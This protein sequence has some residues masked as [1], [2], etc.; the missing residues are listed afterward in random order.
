MN[1][2]DIEKYRAQ[3]QKALSDTYDQRTSANECERFLVSPAAQWEGFARGEA[4][5]RPRYQMDIISQA[6]GRFY[7]EW[8]A[9]RPAVKYRSEGATA[10]KDAELLTGL[11]RKD[12]SRAGGNFA[13]NNAVKSALYGGYG[14]MKLVA[15]YLDNENDE[16]DEQSI[17]F[18]PVYSAYSTVV[19]VGG[20][21]QDKADSRICYE[22]TE[23]SEEDWDD[24]YP[25]FDPSS[26]MDIED[27]RENGTTTYVVAKR[28]EV[29]SEKTEVIYFENLETRDK[30]KVYADEVEAAMDEL[31]ALGYVETA[32]RKMNRQYVECC[33]LADEVLEKPRRIAGKYIPIV[34]FYGRWVF[35]DGQEQY[36]G[37]VRRLMDAQRLTNMAVSNVAEVSAFSPLRVPYFTTD[38]VKGHENRLAQRHIGMTTFQ[39]VNPQKN[40]DGSIAAMGPVGYDEPPPVP[41]ATAS[42]IDICTNYAQQQ[43]G[44]NPADAA[45]S[46]ASFKT[47]L[48][49]QTRI[50]MNT[51]DIVE[52]IELSMLRVGEVYRAMAAEVHS[53][54]K[55]ASTMGA[56]GIES[57]VTM[58]EIIWDEDSGQFI[59]ISDVSN[60]TFNV[61]V[62]VG[63]SYR[64]MRQQSAEEMRNLAG[65]LDPADPMRK[66]IIGTM[67]ENLDVTN[68]DDLSKYNRRQ[69]LTGGFVDPRNEEEEALLQQMAEAQG[70]E[71]GD[72][73]QMFL[74]ASAQEKAAQAAESESKIT[75]NQANAGRAAAQADLYRSQTVEKIQGVKQAMPRRL[76]M[77]S[78]RM[79]Q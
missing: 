3:C 79:M 64:S 60:G 71:S 31:D 63:P 40:D 14:A 70:Q 36:E 57:K 30:K 9:N 35:V 44:G 72:P 46:D 32:R 6:I 51:Q 54:F 34:P 8:V 49:L 26:F 33:V 67:I 11:Y 24:Q 62:D 59:T 1:S 2:D 15:K 37:M 29:K 76:L 43:T 65:M 17:F 50:D 74:M 47:N 42:L 38:Q 39:V 21:R 16:V 20:K 77:Q 52:S 78:P 4:D 18:E 5:F 10:D 23:L 7:G 48:A 56:D 12:E 66:L 41:Q 53:G 55:V 22:L 25:K 45:V 75:L 58:N 28:Y 27:M 73:T 19:W 69:L 13:I 68:A 61:V